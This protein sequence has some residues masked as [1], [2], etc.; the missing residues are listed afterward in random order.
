MLTLADG[1]TK[2]AVLTQAPTNPEAIP[3]ADLNSAIDGG[4]WI[5]KPDFRMSP[6]DSDTV[7]DQPIAQ[8]GNAV[9]FGNGNFEARITVLR[10]LDDD[11][12]SESGGDELWAAVNTKGTRIWLVKRVGPK[13]TEAWTEGDEYLWC[14]AITD[15]PQEPQDMAG[16]VKHIVPL[17]PQAWGRGVVAG[18]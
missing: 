3:A 17:G 11:G 18:A 13:E 9:T 12:V 2:L 6:T 14:E 5:N 8:A 7:P 1:R 16:Y 4:Q 10:D 15:E